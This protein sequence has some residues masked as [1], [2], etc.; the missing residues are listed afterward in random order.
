MEW[1]RDSLNPGW[2]GSMIGIVGVI[3]A[4]VIYRA[5]LI[6][7]SPVYQRRSLRLIGPDAKTLHEG[8]EIRFKG[9]PIERLTK[10]LM[11]FWNSGR[12]LIRGSDVVDIDPIRCDFSVGSRILEVRVVKRNRATNKF[13]AQVDQNLPHRAIVDFDYLDPG[14]GAVL[15]MLHTDLKR[16]P[17]VKGTIRGVPS[18]IVDWG[19]IPQPLNRRLPF[20][21]TRPR[22]VLATAIAFGAFLTAAGILFPEDMLERLSNERVASGPSALRISLVVIGVIYTALPLFVIWRIRRRFPRNLAGPEL[23]E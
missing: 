10:T 4:L 13:D 17:E 8:V 20:P 9:E 11:V 21:F 22:I 7:A 16:Y 2:V 1:I 3:I 19:P 5:S 18:G 23:E 15:E 14:D 12:T 6:G